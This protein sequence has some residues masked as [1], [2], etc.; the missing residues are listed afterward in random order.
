MATTNTAKKTT[1]KKTTSSTTDKPNVDEKAIQTLQAENEELKAKMDKLMEMMAGQPEN[2]SNAMSNNRFTPEDEI[3]VVSL[4]PYKLNL[5][6]EKNGSGNVYEF[7]ELYEEQEIPWSD[8]KDIVRANRKMAQ[9]GRFYILND[10]AVGALR[11]RTHYKNMLTPDQFQ[12]ILD[13]N[14]TK[15]IELYKIAPPG[16]QSIIIEMLKSQ[17]L[18]HEEVDINV[19]YSIGELAGIDLINLTNPNDIPLD[20][21]GAK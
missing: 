10:A 16:Q 21:E 3:T 18:N 1:A 15:T 9:N 7:H 6:T 2:N 20:G 13:K 4:V 12:E 14:P 11:L 19:L 8:L 17:K 5:S